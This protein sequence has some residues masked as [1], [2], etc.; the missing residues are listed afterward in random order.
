MSF[1]SQKSIQS[2]DG[3]KEIS[4]YN[5]RP[6]SQKFSHD[7]VKKSNP[8][9]KSK[10]SESTAANT[11]TAK[12]STSRIPEKIVRDLRATRGNRLASTAPVSVRNQDVRGQ[13]RNSRLHTILVRCG[14]RLKSVNLEGFGDFLM[15]EFC[16]TLQAY[17]NAHSKQLRMAGLESLTICRAN[18]LRDD[19]YSLVGLFKKTLKKLVV[20]QCR[21]ILQAQA[22]LFSH[23]SHC[24]KLEFLD[25]SQCRFLLSKTSLRAIP[26]SLTHL[27]IRRL[28][29]G[30]E[31]DAVSLIAESCPGLKTLIADGASFRG[32]E[33][34]KLLKDFQVLDLSNCFVS[35]AEDGILDHTFIGLKYL[36]KLHLKHSFYVDDTILFYI[37]ANCKALE[38]LDISHPNLYTPTPKLPT[39]AGFMQLAELTQLKS[40]D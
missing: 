8:T 33:L 9:K 18:L 16:S 34:V 21:M 30:V 13:K 26:K 4:G 28:D 2:E 22:A 14:H 1:S 10:V 36:K 12:K 27:V 20:K 37:S 39:E 5:L 19:D 6:R 40:L 24:S 11:P 23:I 29:Q 32:N 31:E 35:D 7:P 3:S 38:E 25:I 17:Y 15:I